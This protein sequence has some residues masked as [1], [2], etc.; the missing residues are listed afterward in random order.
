MATKKQN[1]DANEEVQL[2]LPESGGSYTRDPAT[3]ELTLQACTKTT[4]EDVV[5][6]QIQFPE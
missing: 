1:Q 5:D 3:G 6:D 4:A 2:P